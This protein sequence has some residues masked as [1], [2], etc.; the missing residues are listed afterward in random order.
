MNR[1]SDTD[2]FDATL[3]GGIDKRIMLLDDSFS[4]GAQASMQ[5]FTFASILEWE[6]GSQGKVWNMG[7]PGTSQNRALIAL[8]EYG[9]VMK[10]QVVVAQFYENDYDDNRYPMGIHYSFDNGQWVEICL[11]RR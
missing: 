10:P 5:E 11:G 4:F 2:S 8:R 1:D 6:I 7:I 9:P 3:R